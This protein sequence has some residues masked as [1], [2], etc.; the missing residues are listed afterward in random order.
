[1]KKHIYIYIAFLVVGISNINAQDYFSFY[2]LGDYVVQTQ[3]VSPVYIPKN[4]FTFAVPVANL[5]FN[6]NSG[7]KVNELL[8][9]NENTNKLEYNLANLYNEAGD[10]NDMNVDVTI[11]LFYMAF[12]RKRGSLTIF[13]N[14]RATNNW[15]YTKD[16]L[17]IAANGITSDFLLQE[18][19]EYT[20]YNEIGIG[21]TQTFF[22]DRLALAVRAKYLNGFV[23]SSTEDGA[24]AALEIDESGNF[25]LSAQN[26]TVNSAGSF[27]NGDSEEEFKVFTENTGF[28]FDFG[29]TFKATKK[30]TFEIAVNDIGSITWKEDVKN[31]NIED[32]DRE[33]YS[34]VDLRSRA[35]LEDNALDRIEAIF[36]TN[37]TE[38]EFETKLNMK[39]YLSARYALTEKNTFTLAAFNTHAFDEFKPSYSL[40]YNRTLKKTTFGVLAS[41]GGIDNDFLFGANFAMKLGPLQLYAATDSLKAL[42]AKPEEAYGANVRV[43]LNFVFGYNKHIKAKEAA[44]AE[45]Q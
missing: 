45:A 40:G 29:A 23:H 41:M 16:F 4:S 32:T 15:R 19:N 34:G 35:G 39:T 12:K 42:F 8:V 37:E 33:V 9:K 7:F 22:D 20:G 30:L 11:N 27:F 13:A 28:G 5:G 24:M 25:I 6:F 21:F 38:E 36:Q 1:M 44:E 3:N 17:G 10:F 26:A 18:Q 31:F 43:G 2:N 14:T